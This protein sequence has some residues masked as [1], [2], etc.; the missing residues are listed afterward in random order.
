MISI[1][2]GMKSTNPIRD[3]RSTLQMGVQSFATALGVC[4]PVIYDCERRASL[5]R[6]AATKRRVLA[7]LAALGV[8]ITE[9]IEYC[10]D[11]AESGHAD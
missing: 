7:R 5:P 1:L 6:K 9:H 10:V 4:L 8:L 2:R 3:A 11:R